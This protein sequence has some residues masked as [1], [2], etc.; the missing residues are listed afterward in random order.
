MTDDAPPIPPKCQ[1]RVPAVL[2][3]FHGEAVEQ[4]STQYR[5]C[6][7]DLYKFHR[8]ALTSSSTRNCTLARNASHRTSRI[9]GAWPSAPP[10]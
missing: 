2:A 4:V 9:S 5:M 8:R 1:R 3:L 10:R 6:R 7:S